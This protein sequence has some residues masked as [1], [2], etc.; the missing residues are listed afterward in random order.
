MSVFLLYKC[1]KEI[2]LMVRF[3]LNF[4]HRINQGE[5]TGYIQYPR[6]RMIFCEQ[7]GKHAFDLHIHIKIWTV[8]INKGCKDGSQKPHLT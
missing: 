4:L 1:K 8:R 2:G 3:A 5:A 6:R 7:R